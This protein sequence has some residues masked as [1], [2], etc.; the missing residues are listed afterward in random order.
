MRRS[1]VQIDGQLAEKTGP[2]SAILAGV[3]YYNFGGRWLAENGPGQTAPM[4]MNDIQPYRSQIDGSWI[5]SR[6][7]HRAHLRD[8]GMIEVGNEKVVN[9]KP[10]WTVTRGLRE[11]LISRIYG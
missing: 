8:H 10:T 5:T 2:N 11:E 4:V 3:N 7:A 6:S 1:Y 9:P